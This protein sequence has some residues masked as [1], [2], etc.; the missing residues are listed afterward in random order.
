[1]TITQDTD[2]FTTDWQRWHAQRVGAAKAAYG[3]AAVTGTHWLGAEPAE[4]PGVPG[5]W[6]VRD[7]RVV[8]TDVVG[9]PLDLE[10][11]TAWRL[12]ETDLEVRVLSRGDD[13]AIRVVDPA[14]E[15]RSALVDIDAYE[16]DP[17]WVVQGRFAPADAGATIT[18]D[19]ADGAVLDDPLAGRIEV[20]LDGETHSLAAFPQA[21]GGLQVSFSDTTSGSET[22][23]F[24]FVTTTAPDDQGRVS[25]DFNRAYLPPS[26]FTAHYLCPLPP[27]G[28][29]LATAIRAGEKLPRTSADDA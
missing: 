14:A 10:V 29:R 1:M 6:S 18:I 7:G 16:P 13:V 23:R 28:N 3:L 20:E 21:D 4:Y 17:A 22:A 25:I 19:H 26:T 12:G 5:R 27:A 9:A 24:R 8:G 15:T 11:G 2:T